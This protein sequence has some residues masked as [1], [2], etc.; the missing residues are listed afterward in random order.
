MFHKD[1]NMEKKSPWSDMI[2]E[3]KGTCRKKKKQR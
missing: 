2:H 1:W 3:D